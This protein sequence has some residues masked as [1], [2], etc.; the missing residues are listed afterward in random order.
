MNGAMQL[1]Y[2]SFPHFDLPWV[3]DVKSN[4]CHAIK[5][6]ALDT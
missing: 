5:K 1:I 4:V 6:I 3:N 2:D